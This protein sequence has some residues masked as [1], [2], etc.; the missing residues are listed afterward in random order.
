MITR[1]F[2]SIND[3]DVTFT[4]VQD[5][6]DYW[7]GIGPRVEGLQ[8]IVIWAETEQGSVRRLAVSVAISW[9]TETTVRLV[10]MPFVTTLVS[11]YLTSVVPPHIRRS[12][13]G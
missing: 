12:L 5:R 3:V 1:V 2:G 8:N 10:L 4:P 11:A 13:I 7:E 9:D 6:P